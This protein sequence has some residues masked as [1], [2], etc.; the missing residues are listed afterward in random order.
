MNPVSVSIQIYEGKPENQRDVLYR[1]VDKRGVSK[2][3]RQKTKVKDK[4]KQ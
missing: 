2:D 1:I 4:S 3:K